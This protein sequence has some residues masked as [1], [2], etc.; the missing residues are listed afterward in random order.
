MSTYFIKG[1]PVKVLNSMVEAF[2]LKGLWAERH[3]YSLRIMYNNRFA[4]SLHLYPGFNEAVLRLIS[5]DPLINSRIRS[6]VKEIMSI[7]LPGYVVREVEV[8]NVLDTY[9]A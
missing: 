9:N 8:K 2:R 4:A 1:I 6:I 5:G 7:Y 3:S